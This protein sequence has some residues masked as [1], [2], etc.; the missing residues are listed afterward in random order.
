M[1]I[2]LKAGHI[3]I[4][5]IGDILEASINPVNNKHRVINQQGVFEDLEVYWYDIAPV[6]KEVCDEVFNKKVSEAKSAY[7]AIF[8]AA[9]AEKQTMYDLVEKS[10]DA[11]EKAAAKKE[12]DDAVAEKAAAQKVIDDDITEKARKDKATTD[13]AIELQEKNSIEA[14]ALLINKNKLE[15]EIDVIKTN[16]EIAEE[17]LLTAE[18]DLQIFNEDDSKKGTG[19]IEE[20]NGLVSEVEK[21]QANLTDTNKKLEAK[22]TELNIIL[23]KIS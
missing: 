15:S 6:S 10:K 17:V 7:N 12:I 14:Q 3:R 20:H 1:L 5:K 4:G 13:A 9:L 23:K 16:V 22:I 2:I 19:F 8:E 21:K 11:T 18:A